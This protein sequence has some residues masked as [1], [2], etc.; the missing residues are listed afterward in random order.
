[1]DPR[2]ILGPRNKSEDVP[3]T[4]DDRSWNDNMQG[5]T[6][7]AAGMSI[8]KTHGPSYFRASWATQMRCVSAVVSGWSNIMQ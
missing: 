2:D 6:Q 3:G 1:M 7:R 8:G 5:S 4:E